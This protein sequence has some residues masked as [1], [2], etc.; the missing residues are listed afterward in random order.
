MSTRALQEPTQNTQTKA[1]L[2]TFISQIGPAANRGLLI[3]RTRCKPE[4]HR[5]RQVDEQ[6][7]MS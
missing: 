2:N 3:Q 4:G 7:D 6:T 1:N 5:G